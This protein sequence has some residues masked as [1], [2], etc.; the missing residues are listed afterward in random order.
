[1]QRDPYL[2]Y[3]TATVYR[4]DESIHTA[5]LLQIALAAP[6]GSRPSAMGVYV[7]RLDETIAEIKSSR[8]EIQAKIDAIKAQP[9][10]WEE[11]P[12]VVKAQIE[13]Q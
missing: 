5:E 6:D 2:E 13:K 4:M 10:T 3:L 11:Q 9:D 7:A 1:M 12:D 8:E